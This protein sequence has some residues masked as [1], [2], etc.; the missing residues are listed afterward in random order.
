MVGGADHGAGHRR[1]DRNYTTGRDNQGAGL[2]AVLYQRLAA[3][4]FELHPP[5]E[6]RAETLQL[7]RLYDAEM[8]Y[9][10]DELLAP[11]RFWGHKIGVRAA[12]RSVAP[13]R[14]SGLASGD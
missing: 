14:T 11:R 13:D 3:H 5:D 7:R 8:E 1:L 10:I 2:L 6:A 12:V 9:L 4:G